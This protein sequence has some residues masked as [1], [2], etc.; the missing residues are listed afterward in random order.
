MNKKVSL[1]SLN[2]FGCEIDDTSASLTLLDDY[3]R[4]KTVGQTE[5]IPYENI[6]DVVKRW[7]WY[8]I[9]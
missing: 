4:V 9:S 7:W 5:D 1:A 6:K 2:L 3:L 8:E